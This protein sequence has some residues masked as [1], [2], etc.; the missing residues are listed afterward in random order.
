MPVVIR[1]LGTPLPE[2][3]RTEIPI[4]SEAWTGQWGEV[5]GDLTEDR[6]LTPEE[7]DWALS[8]FARGWG[9]EHPEAELKYVEI[10]TGSPRHIRAQYIIRAPI[11]G[12]WA[13]L[14]T[15]L[16]GLWATACAHAVGVGVAVAIMAVGFALWER[17]R[18]R[19][20]HFTCGIC[21]ETCFSSVDEL[22]V[23]ILTAHPEKDSDLVD[24]LKKAAEHADLMYYVKIGIII[25][26]GAVAFS[27]A[28]PAIRG[29][30]V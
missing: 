16:A 9:I 17:I 11:A 2:S 14:A 25:V 29:R 7:Y 22:A 20:D 24:K 26:V 27:I 19:Q 8:Y 4:E 21:G 15:W 5:H 10:S 13:A 1:S 3:A 28:W 23:H 6:P 12:F 18:P 30:G